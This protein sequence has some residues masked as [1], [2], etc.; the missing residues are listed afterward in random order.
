MLAYVTGAVDELLL[1]RIEYL[2]EENRVLRGQV[3]GRVLLTDPERRNLAEKAVALGKLMTDTVTIV[4]PDTIL[5]WHRRLVAEKYDG[6]KRRKSGGRPPVAPEI[7]MQVVAMAGE[8]PS[9]G[10]DRIAGAMRNLGHSISDQTVGNILKRHGMAPSGG[11]KR[12]TTWAAFIRQHR[13]VLWAADFFTSEIWARAG[14]TTFYVLFFIHL[15]TRKIVLGGL[16]QSPNGQWMKQVAR[17]MTD[18]DSEMVSARYLIHDRDSKFT[19]AFDELL[20]ASGVE[21]VRLP[22]RSPDLNAFAERFVRS[23]KEECLDR[24]ILFGEKSLRYTIKEY[25]AHYHS[26]RNHQ[27]IGNVIPFPDERLNNTGKMTKSERL[28]GLLNFYHRNAA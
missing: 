5:R 2:I 1:R 27:G 26:E 15:K 17:N 20:D 9:W 28:G 12:N 22:P 25:L 18:F 6:S 24:M 11:R 4:K 7:E 14:L 19:A 13:D 10:Y 23:I 21:P 8:N 16:T 3:S